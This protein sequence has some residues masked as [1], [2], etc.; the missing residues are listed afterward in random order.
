MKTLF[1]TL[2]AM[3]I[4]L[5]ACPSAFGQAAKPRAATL[6]QQKMCA[7][8]ARKTFHEN[9]PKPNATTGYTS[10]YDAT[11]NVC[12]IMVHYL[13]MSHGYPSVSDTVYDAFEGREYASYI[14][15]NPEK[16]KAWE[17]APMECS[18]KPRGQDEVPCTSPEEFEKLVDKYFG[19]GR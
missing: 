17:V 14:W 11:A 9:N 12:Y 4:V 18:V 6:S 13:D 3:S 8:Q 7:E 1:V 16:K 15:I 5:A 10:H 19:I 2:G